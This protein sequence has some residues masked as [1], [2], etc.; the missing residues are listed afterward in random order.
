MPLHPWESGTLP[1]FETGTL[2]V[3]TTS[4]DPAARLRVI[5]AFQALVD[6]RQARWHT[7][8][9]G[10]TE[11]HLDSGEVFLLRPHSVTRLR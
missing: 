8:D 2:A 10:R 6:A 1:S 5:S 9:S 7:D 3:G 11:L 4:G